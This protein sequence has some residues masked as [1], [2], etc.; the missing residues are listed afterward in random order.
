LY[1]WLAV[2][3]SRKIAPTG[4][5]VASNAEW[6]TLVS[7]LGGLDVAGGKLKEAGTAHWWSPNN[8]AT[9][10]SGFTALPAGYRTADGTFLFLGGGGIWWTTSSFDAANAFSWHLDYNYFWILSG[11]TQKKEGVSVR[12]VKD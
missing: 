6:N 4:W 8:G 11:T 5:H 12:C 3:D 7:F 1:N 9:N 2:S 10:V